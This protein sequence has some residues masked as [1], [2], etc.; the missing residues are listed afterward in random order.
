MNLSKI[1]A[2]LEIKALS[3]DG[4]F[5]GYGSVFDNEDSYGDV[6]EKGAF[7][8]S[9]R[10]W[11]KQGKLPKLLWQHRTDQPIGVYTAMKE[12]DR[13][14][15]VE[16]RL[17]KDDVKLASET[18]AL[19]QAGAVD[20]LSIGF[21]TKVDEY[22]RNNKVRK[23]KEVELFEVSVVTFPANTSAMVEA[24]KAES[25]QTIRD[26]E[27]FLKSHGFTATQ[28]KNIAASGFKS[29]APNDAAQRLLQVMQGHK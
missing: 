27:H 10:Q 7:R 4:T 12:D 23:L 22:D 18:Y 29:K 17:L 5:T 26:F 21:R 1:S 20:G 25:V 11:R 14:L 8:K 19:M 6:V 13:G 2:P 3:S 15:Y 9:L 24:V 28:A 16:G